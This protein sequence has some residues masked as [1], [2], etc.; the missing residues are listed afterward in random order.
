MLVARRADERRLPVT[1]ARHVVLVLRQRAKLGATRDA[2][3]RRRQT[4]SVHLVTAEL[5]ERAERLATVRTRPRRC[6]LLAR[7]LATRRKPR[8]ASLSGR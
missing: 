5:V 2:A 8:G 1:G 3:E 6:G 7:R 4:M